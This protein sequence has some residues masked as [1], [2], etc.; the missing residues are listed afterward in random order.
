MLPTPHH[1]RSALTTVLFRR[2]AAE[3][4]VEQEAK[5]LLEEELAVLTA[6]A[7]EYQRLYD[8]FYPV[9]RVLNFDDDE[10]VAMDIDNNEEV[11]S[12]DDDDDK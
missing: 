10:P 5:R 8:Q 12:S 6:E 4:D 1:H 7:D 11:P 2:V 3:L 9:A